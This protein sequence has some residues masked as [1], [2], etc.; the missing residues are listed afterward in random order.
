M[1]NATHVAGM[2]NARVSRAVS[3]GWWL[4]CPCTVPA[5]DIG[6]AIRLVRGFLAP[7]G[8]FKMFGPWELLNVNAAG[9]YD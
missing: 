1:T 2:C 8:N 7:L 4:G 6:I 9:D 3:F 5:K